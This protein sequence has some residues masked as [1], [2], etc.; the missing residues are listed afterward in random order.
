MV[1]IE[2]RG[3]DGEVVRAPERPSAPGLWGLWAVPSSAIGE[4]APLDFGWVF[5]LSVSGVESG[6]GHLFRS[7]PGVINLIRCSPAVTVARAS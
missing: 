1:V 5:S 6:Q 7:V 3:E 4:P 2:S